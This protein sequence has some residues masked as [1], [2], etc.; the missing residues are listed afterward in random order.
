M[1]SRL[2]VS[3]VIAA[4]TEEQRVAIELACYEGMSQ[5]EIAETLGTPLGTI[6]TR[7]RDGLIRLKGIIAPRSGN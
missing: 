1:E 7:I 4:L 3:R 2:L 6:K 5:S